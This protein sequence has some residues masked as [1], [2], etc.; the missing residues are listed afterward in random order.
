MAKRLKVGATSK[1]SRWLFYSRCCGICVVL[2][3]TIIMSDP[4]FS[5]YR[6]LRP[7]TTDWYRECPALSPGGGVSLPR[8]RQDEPRRLSPKGRREPPSL[9]DRGSRGI[10]LP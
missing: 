10:P 6:L 1:D 5:F 8:R 3:S 7:S 9:P 4:C 2:L